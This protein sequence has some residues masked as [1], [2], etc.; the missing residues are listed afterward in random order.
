MTTVS[1]GGVPS[2][3][4]TLPERKIG[5]GTSWKVV[6]WFCVPE[7]VPGM[8]VLGMR[9]VFPPVLPP[10][11]RLVPVPEP[12]PPD[13]GAVVAGGAVCWP[14]ACGRRKTD[15]AARA[16]E[17][18]LEKGVMD[19]SRDWDY[20]ATP[21]RTA[22]GVSVL[23]VRSR[24]GEDLAALPTVV[25]IE[26]RRNVLMKTPLV[27]AGTALILLLAGC[28]DAPKIAEKKAPP[29]AAE[30]VTGQ[31]ALYKMYQ[32]ARTWAP[33]LEVLKMV[34][35]QMPDVKAEPGKAPAWEATFVSVSRGKA[36]SYTFSVVEGEGNLHKGVFAG[37]EEGWSGPR[38]V[39]KPFTIQAVKT[40]TDAAYKEALANKGADYEKKNP[41]K[42]ITFLLEKNNKFPDPSWRVI[43][44]ESVGTSNF[45]VYVD[46]STGAFQEIFH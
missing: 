39:T 35:M 12:E 44:G 37:I 40:D 22:P 42:P 21:P 8:V 32:V 27:T 10:G 9:P 18:V 13:G 17:S 4:M 3:S 15:A 28:S 36:R 33:D 31:S 46:C 45:S 11:G 1:G 20:Y 19:T 25:R 6:F 43:W 14:E 41:G 30:P 7:L 16:I 34:S 23:T 26:S 2:S 24:G 29:P 5:R 38:G